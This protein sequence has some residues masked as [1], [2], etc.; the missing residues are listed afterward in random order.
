MNFKQKIVRKNLIK[1][2]KK[3][4]KQFY[5]DD[6]KEITT[7]EFADKLLNMNMADALALQKEIKRKKDEENEQDNK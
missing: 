2:L 3:S 4:K 6:G 1:L 7:E 5:D